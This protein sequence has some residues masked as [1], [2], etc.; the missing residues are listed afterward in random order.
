MQ[1]KGGTNMS[2]NN[3][4]SLKNSEGNTDVLMGFLRSG[5][6]ELITKAVHTEL[7]EFLSQYQDMTDSKGRPWVVRN[8]YLPQREIMTGIGPVD[9]KFLRPETEVGKV[10]ILG[11][12]CYSRISNAPRA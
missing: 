9:I 7:A 2:K 1:N 11:Q 4:I 5:S 12:S 6:R 10:F 8:G 3:I